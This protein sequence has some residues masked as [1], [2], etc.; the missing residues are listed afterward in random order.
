MKV[1][2][3]PVEMSRYRA[4]PVWR[5]GVNAEQWRTVAQQVRR[6]RTHRGAV[7]FRPDRPWAGLEFHRSSPSVPVGL[8]H[9]AGRDEQPEFPDVSDIFPAAGRMQRAVFD[10]LGVAPRERTTTGSG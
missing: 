9:I 4:I 3:F 5:G 1:E 2:D 10:L 8:A 6:R 7:G